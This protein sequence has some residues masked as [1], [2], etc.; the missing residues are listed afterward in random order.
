[1]TNRLAGMRL[2]LP[3]WNNSDPSGSASVGRTFNFAL[4]V[5]SEYIS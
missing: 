5:F 4:D 1:M 2:P 3:A